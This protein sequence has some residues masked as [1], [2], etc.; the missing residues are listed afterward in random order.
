MSSRS[1]TSRPRRPVTPTNHTKPT[2]ATEEPTEVRF[3]IEGHSAG[4][5]A[6]IAIRRKG[7]QWAVIDNRAGNP[8]GPDFWDGKFWAPLTEKYQ[9]LAY[10]WTREEAETLAKHEA[11]IA[12]EVH[13]RYASMV[14]PEFAD[15]L[16]GKTE[17]LVATVREA[18]A[19]A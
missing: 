9:H 5:A 15:W 12:S 8:F 13:Q 18:V 10:R 3:P 2:A 16:A 19:A 11:E 7:D 17:T 6:F 4:E 1:K 14:R